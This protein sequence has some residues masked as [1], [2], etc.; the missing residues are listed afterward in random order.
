MQKF[1]VS[2][3][4][5]KRYSVYALILLIGLI[6]RFSTPL[7]TLLDPDA[8]GYLAPAL[9][10]LVNGE[11]NHVYAR[12]YTYPT[13]LTAVLYLFKNIN[14]IAIVQHI[15]GLSSII[16]LLYIIEN[17]WLNKLNEK[18]YELIA[19]FTT[20][21]FAA[22][23]CWNANIIA[24]EKMLRPE[25]LIMPSLFLLLFSIFFY[26][27]NAKNKYKVLLYYF[28]VFLL[29]NFA[30]LHPRFLAAFFF[31]A[32]ILF[33]NQ[34]QY[35][36]P[37][38]KKLQVAIFTG[39][40]FIT[41]FFPENYLINK[42]DKT[43]PIFSLKQFFYSHSPTVL[44]AINNDIAVEHYYD[45]NELRNYLT[46]ALNDEGNRDEK[47]HRI[48]KFNID[49]VQYGMDSNSFK[50][51][52]YMRKIKKDK[53]IA[54]SANYTL[55]KEDTIKYNNAAFIDISSELNYYYVNWVKVLLLNYPMDI[56]KKVGRQ[57]TYL[58]TK[59]EGDFVTYRAISMK[60]TF[61]EDRKELFNY[62]KNDLRY[63]PLEQIVLKEP[64][65]I[66]Q[67]NYFANLP[68]R[69]LYILS[70]MM[71]IYLYVKKGVNHI[72]VITFFML[73]IYI[74]T[75]AFLHTFDIGR[76]LLSLSPLIF[77]FILFCLL[78]GILV[79]DVLSKAINKK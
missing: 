33:L 60:Q 40:I 57:L 58:Y 24:F 70:L 8:T 50:Y 39:L 47:Q 23:I 44:K 62:L 11:F 48:M 36:K 78:E 77:A 65:L 29:F 7:V 14:A 66:Q 32:I 27:Y 19:S 61:E 37:V 71:G 55:T 42:Y 6:L 73:L 38:V 51:Y 75:T 46:T 1:K 10:F 52:T 4:K 20:I 28:N 64:K 34:M 68:L 13:F 41:C 16:L 18:K 15:I 63:K 59:P 49:K 53:G 3:N 74:L 45:K 30:L 54:I 72:V 67:F 5:K 21:F 35:I 76:Y 9:G 26:L 17:H 69:F 56:I 25:G 79:V 22:E 31:I 12:S 2:C 43:A